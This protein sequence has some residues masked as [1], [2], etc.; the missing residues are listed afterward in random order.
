[1]KSDIIFG[2]GMHKCGTTWLHACLYEHPEICIPL[3]GSR[4]FSDPNINQKGNLWYHNL[5]DNHSSLKNCRIDFC[6]DYSIK[7]GTIEKIHN[8]NPDAKIFI[9]LRDPVKRAISHLYQD[10][11]QGLVSYSKELISL[12]TE[13]SLYVQRGKYKSLFDEIFM[14]FGKEQIH[15]MYMSD[16][17]SD[18]TLLLSN[19]FQFLNVDSNFKSSQKNKIQNVSRIPKS[20]WLERIQNDIYK[21]LKGNYIGE[22]IWWFSNKTGLGKKIRSVNSDTTKKSITLSEKDQQNIRS[23]FIEDITYI[24][25]TFGRG[26]LPW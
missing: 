26:D 14:F 20:L 10:L 12:I 2:L 23:Y 8:Y 3:R 21:G 25:D 19:L 15:V 16:I 6:N 18:S 13:K 22:K 1:M 11:K 24:K 5:F 17:A 4:F 7:P 9:I